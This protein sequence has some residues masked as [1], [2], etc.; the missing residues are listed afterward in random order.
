[1]RIT[2]GRSEA[3]KTSGREPGVAGG[4]T[5]NES[6]SSAAPMKRF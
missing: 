1:M 6:I 5:L 3:G 2:R 4:A